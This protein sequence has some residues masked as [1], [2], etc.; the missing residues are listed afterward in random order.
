M[1]ALLLTTFIDSLYR[2][3]RENQIITDLFWRRVNYFKKVFD[4]YLKRFKYILMKYMLRR[5]L[6]EEHGEQ[7]IKKLVQYCKKNKI[8]SCMICTESFD[9]HPYPRTLPELQAYCEGLLGKTMSAL[10]DEGIESGINT[11]Y[12]LGCGDYGMDLTS[13]SNFRFTPY[14]DSHGYVAKGIASPLCPQWRSYFAQALHFF[15]K[16]QPD[17]I[18][19]DDDFRLH[20]HLPANF[21]SFDPLMIKAFNHRWSL[22][23]DRQNLVQKIYSDYGPD[24]IREKWQIFC[25]EVMTETAE[26]IRRSIHA[27]NP[28]IEVGLMSSD[29][30]VHSAEGRNWKTMTKAFMGKQK[31]FLLRPMMGNYRQTDWRKIMITY[32]YPAFTLSRLDCPVRACSEVESGQ[33]GEFAKSETMERAQHRLGILGGC[34]DITLNIYDFVGQPLGENAHYDRA[35]RKDYKLLKSLEEAC[36]DTK[37]RG[38]SIWNHARGSLM[39]PQ[40]KQFEQIPPQMVWE[41]VMSLQGYGVTYDHHDSVTAITG[42]AIQILSDKEIQKILKGKVLLD[43]SAAQALIE[44]GFE[45]AIGVKITGKAHYNEGLGVEE[46]VDPS[47]PI[48]RR[49]LAIRHMN[50][51]TYSYPLETV[52][53]SREITT[54]WKHIGERFG[55]GMI[56]HQNKWGGRVVTITQDGQ[57]GALGFAEDG[58]RTL[59]YYHPVRKKLYDEVFQF[60]NQG[61]LPIQITQG[62]N[63]FPIRRDGKNHSL[64]AVQSFSSDTIPYE[65]R[66]DLEGRK[67]KK[68]ESLELSGKWI[69]FKKYKKKE[70]QLTLESKIQ[71]GFTDL[72]RVQ[73]R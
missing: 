63:L 27:V 41:F 19:I 37:L 73:Y 44:R 54:V 17:Y 9:R 55:A 1:R 15:S 3:L 26:F 10:R 66:V 4:F 28:Q 69:P 53:G 72:Y 8:E 38:V 68:I 36:R 48:Y 58:G 70:N 22:S 30:N 7:E 45:E 40:V 62:V 5:I 39:T 67:I 42:Y 31:T 11:I 64:L 47:L 59:C 2:L 65:L 13:D 49:Q 33:G 52:H 56:W 71:H 21:G 34:Q 24:S 25:G 14:V 18:F 32:L 35:L 20:N 51:Q 23:L 12:D 61:V 43:S 57:T 60:L 6:I 29:P 16:T 46:I 50:P